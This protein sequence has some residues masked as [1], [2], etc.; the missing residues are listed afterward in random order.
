MKK[1]L[2][3]IL[4]F[5]I[6][7]YIIYTFISQRKMLNSYAIEKSEYQNE[8]VESKKEQNELN[9]ELQNLNS[10]EYV[11]GVAR[12]KLDMYLPNERVFVDMDK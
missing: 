2:L 10:T 11:E 3:R 5:F 1:I 8:I 4:L 12:D 9:D 6:I 7:V